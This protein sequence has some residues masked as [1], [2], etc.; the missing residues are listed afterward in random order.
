[1]L[2]EYSRTVWSAKITTLYKLV[3]V[4]IYGSSLIYRTFGETFHEYIMCVISNIKNFI[5]DIMRPDFHNYSSKLYY[6]AIK[7]IRGMR[8]VI[9]DPRL[10][11]C[12]KL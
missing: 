11:C 6:I 1:M 2:I 9:M 12:N 5:S 10:L 7:G 4:L 3:Q 8:K